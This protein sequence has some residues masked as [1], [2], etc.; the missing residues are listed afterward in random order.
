MVENLR[1]NQFEI[2][3]IQMPEVEIESR[4]LS[5]LVG[6]NG[7]GK[8]V[9]LK[10]RWLL[11]TTLASYVAI[12]ASGLDNPDAQMYHLID[13]LIEGTF[14]DIETIHGGISI[15][16]DICDFNISLASGKV[17]YFEVNIKNRAAF[18]KE[19]SRGASFCSK[20]TRT[21]DQYQKYL[22]L[23]NKLGVDSPEKIK[24]MYD[25]YKLYDIQRFEQLANTLASHARGDIDLMPA[26]NNVIYTL[27]SGIKEDSL[28][29]IEGIPW[30]TKENSRLRLA[31]LSSGEQSMFMLT[32]FS[33]Q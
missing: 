21:F 29:V 22:K 33:P 32:A 9:V 6:V 24:D 7:S 18:V 19:A 26:F 25:F 17:Q 12:L 2:A 14:S 30:A 16:N 10:I 15:E 27:G 13:E 11:G 1:F 3:G 4:S 28:E 5:V 23:K 20:N 31:S 8:S